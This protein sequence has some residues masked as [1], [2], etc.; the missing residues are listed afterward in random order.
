MLDDLFG[1]SKSEIVNAMMESTKIMTSYMGAI[2]QIM[3]EK[4]ICTEEE[5]EKAQQR[6]LA[7]ADQYQE[8][9]KEEAM[10]EWREANPEKAKTLDFMEKLFKPKN[11]DD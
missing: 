5:V 7:Y 2:Y 8:G 4:G 3:L 11:K 6:L 1:P 9:H 10:K